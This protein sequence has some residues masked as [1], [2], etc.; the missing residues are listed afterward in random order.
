MYSLCS[1]ISM[2]WYAKSSCQMSNIEYHLGVSCSLR[3]LIRQMPGFVAK[4]ISNYTTI[5]YPLTVHYLF[6]DFLNKNKTNWYHRLH[7]CW[8][9]LPVR[10]FLLQN[11]TVKGRCL[12]SI[13]RT[14]CESL[15]EEKLSQRPNSGVSSRTGR[16]VVV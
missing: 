7:I 6:D 15:K 9:H 3:E 12:A 5:I 4:Q 11:S 2:A 13:D 14:E 1:P 16:N 8:E 10:H